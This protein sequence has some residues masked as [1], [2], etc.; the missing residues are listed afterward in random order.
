MCSN[1]K[2]LAER[3]EMRAYL[4]GKHQPQHY[5]FLVLDPMWKYFNELDPTSIHFVQL[6]LP[7]KMLQGLM[8]NVNNKVFK[9]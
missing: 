1:P 2:N 7:F 9:P 6:T 8:V 4:Q 5:P 3:V